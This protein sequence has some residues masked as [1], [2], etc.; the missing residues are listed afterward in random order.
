[1]V[2]AGAE[3]V[4]AIEV[5]RPEALEEIAALHIWTAESIRAD[6]LDFRP[7]HRLTVL[8]VRAYPLVAP[9]RIPRRDE[10]R[11][12]SSWVQLDVAPQW[13]TAVHTESAL[14]RVAQ[15]VRESVGG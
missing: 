1:M 10:H 6:R 11:G 14:A 2:R 3:V 15:R 5:G 4:A 13:G 8:V 9:V 7:K 12:C